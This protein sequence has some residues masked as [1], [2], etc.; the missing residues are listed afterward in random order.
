MGKTFMCKCVCVCVCKVHNKL[1][2]LIC[3]GV[4]NACLF[5]LKTVHVQQD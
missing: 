3:Q 2:I 4:F 5:N 1:E